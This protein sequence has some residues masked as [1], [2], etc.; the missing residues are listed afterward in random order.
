[1]IPIIISISQDAALVG[2]GGVVL[3]SW[4]G[5]GVVLG[6]GVVLVDC[7]LEGQVVV[8]DRCYLHGVT[9]TGKVVDIELVLLLLQLI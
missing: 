3:N 4:V 9:I 6:G 5:E 7:R 2:G 1:M 8:A